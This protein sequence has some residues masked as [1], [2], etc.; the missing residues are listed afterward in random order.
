MAAKLCLVCLEI[1]ELPW[2]SPNRRRLLRVF[3]ILSPGQIWDLSVL[4]QSGGSS[5]T[6]PLGLAT[7]RSRWMST[8]PH[9]GIRGKVCVCLMPTPCGFTSYDRKIPENELCLV[10]FLPVASS[11]VLWPCTTKKDSLLAPLYPHGSCEL[12][13]DPLGESWNLGLSSMQLCSGFLGMQDCC[14]GL[15]CL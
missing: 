11:R 3:R 10:A 14:S 8:F 7:P 4:R 13:T 12:L 9:W 5:E 15:P 2:L 1:Q 6:V